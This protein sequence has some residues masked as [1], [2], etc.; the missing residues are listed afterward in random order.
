MDYPENFDTQAFPSGKRVALSRFAG[1]CTMV[2]LFLIIVMCVAL[3][4]IIKL[5]KIDPTIIY[6]NPDRGVWEVVGKNQS[7]KSVEYYYSVQQSL[8]GVFTQK[9]FTIS[10]NPEINENLWTACNREMDCSKRVERTFRNTTKCELYCI[11]SDSMYNKFKSSVLPLYEINVSFGERWMPSMRT[12]SVSPSGHITEDGGTWLV[13]INVQSNI[14][15]TFSV[16]AYAKVGRDVNRYPQT[17]GYY[18]SDFNSYRV[19]E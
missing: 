1:I 14:K 8:V 3:L 13:R 5:R 17:L 6:I 2:S 19:Q 10:T 12:L 18:I 7:T 11:S 9:W 15:G 4:W 16:L